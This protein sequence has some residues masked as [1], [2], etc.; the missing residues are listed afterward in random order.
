MEYRAISLHQP[1]ASL[2]ALGIKRYETRSWSTK[3]RGKLLICSAKK[4]YV[5]DISFVNKVFDLKDVR[6]FDRTRLDFIGTNTE[7][8]EFLPLGKILCVTDLVD[9][10]KMESYPKHK[11]NIILEDVPELEQLC[12]DWQAVRYAWELANLMTLPKPIPIKGKQG[13][14]IPDSSIIQDIEKQFQ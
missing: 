13:L 1:W 14:W 4:K 12:G 2:V 11:E 8:V 9:C 6:Q 5:P 7:Y 10:L 3:F